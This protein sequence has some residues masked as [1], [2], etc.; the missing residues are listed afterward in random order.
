MHSSVGRS[1]RDEPS[2]LTTNSARY[3]SALRI[4]SELNQQG[5]Q[6]DQAILQR[7]AIGLARVTLQSHASASKIA[8]HIKN[9]KWSKSFWSVRSLWLKR[10]TCLTTI[11]QTLCLLDALYVLLAAP[12]RV[13]FFFD[14]RFGPTQWTT[15]LSV[16]LVLDVLGLMLR[17]Y[18]FQDSLLSASRRLGAWARATAQT[19]VHPIRLRQRLRTVVKKDLGSLTSI[20]RWSVASIGEQFVFNQQALANTQV[21]DAQVTPLHFG[22]IALG[23]IPWEVAA[24][25]VDYN[26]VHIV[27]L[28][29]VLLAAGTLPQRFSATIVARFHDRASIQLLSFSTIGVMV[30]LTILGLYLCHVVG[31]GYMLVAHIECGLRFELCDQQAR[32]PQSWVAKDQ[33]VDGSLSRQYVRTLYWAC[34]TMTTLGQGDLV[35]ATML[36][37]MYRVIVQFLAGLWAT[38]L[39]T[40]CSVF[41]SHKD[42]HINTSKS[43]RLDQIRQFLVSRT[44]PPAVMTNVAAYSTYIQRTRR[45]VE[46]VFVMAQLP[47]HYRV[48]CRNF[49][50]Y[51]YLKR[52]PGFRKRDSRF[53]RALLTIMERDFFVPN[54]VVVGVN[55]A[56]DMLIVVSGEIRVLDEALQPLGRLTP[57]NWHAEHALTDTTISQ[58]LLIADTF[59]ELWRLR[60]S[61][62]HTALGLRPITRSDEQSGARR[63]RSRTDS[64]TLTA[65]SRKSKTQNAAQAEGGA[66]SALKKLVQKLSTDDAKQMMKVARWRMPNSRFQQLWRRAHCILLLFILF[67]IPYHIAFQRGFS[68]F[69]SHEEAWV[70]ATSLSLAQTDFALSVLIEMFFMADMVLHANFFVRASSNNPAVQ[71]LITS[72]SQIF[73]HYL[74][75]E[76]YRLDLLANVPLPLL[77]DITPKLKMRLLSVTYLRYVRLLRLLR[78]RHLRQQLSI[79]MAEY[80]ITPSIRLLVFTIVF[81]G[82]AAHYAGCVFFLVADQSDFHG[83]LPVDFERVNMTA[84]QCLEHA[85]RHGNCTWYIY[86]RHAFDIPAPFLRSLH[87]SIVLLT[88]VGYGD[89]VAY[90][91]VESVVDCIWIFVSALICYFTGCAISSVLAHWHVLHSLQQERLEEI[92]IVLARLPNVPSTTA[93][94]IRNY[95]QTTWQFQGHTMLERELLAH[96]PRSLRYQI[97]ESLYVETLKYCELFAKCRSDEIF[98]QTVAH[99][100][101]T[102]IFLHNVT[103][104]RAGHTAQEVYVIQS[105][106]VEVFFPATQSSAMRR[107]SEAKFAQLYNL[108]QRARQLYAQTRFRATTTGRNMAATLA[109]H[110]HEAPIESLIPVSRLEVGDCFGLESVFLDVPQVHTTSACVVATAQVAVLRR[111]ELMRLRERFPK[112]LELLTST[113]TA[114]LQVHEHLYRN[115]QDNA[116]QRK[117]RRILGI[118]IA[119]HA[120]I[121]RHAKK[122]QTT[123]LDPSSRRVVCWHAAH[124]VIVVYNFYQIIFRIAFLPNP[125]LTTLWWLTAIDYA[126]DVFLYVDIFLKY[127][128][129]GYFEFGEKVLNRP[130]IQERY[131]RGWLMIHCCGMLPTFYIGDAQWMN[132]ARLPRLLRSAQLASLLDD[133]QTKLQ[134]RY[135]HSSTVLLNVFDLCKFFL[136]FVSTAHYIGSLYYLIGRLQTEHDG[137]SWISV[138][139][140]LKDHPHNVAVHYMRAMYWC[141]STFTVDCF[142]DIWAQN[143]LETMFCIFSCVL[144]WIFVGQVITKI[145]MLM[146]TL[147]RDAKEQHERVA[148]FEQLAATHQLPSALRHRA[149]KAL[150]YTSECWVQLQ[151]S[152]TFRDLPYALYVQLCYDMHAPSIAAVPEFSGLPKC[153][154]EAI[155][156]ALRVA[157][158]LRGDVIYDCHRVATTVL[159]VKHGLAELYSPRTNVVYGALAPGMAFATIAIVGSL[160]LFASVRAV[161]SCLVLLL[162]RRTWRSLWPRDVAA[163]VEN[164][165]RPRL[166]AEYAKHV[167]AS[168]NIEKN[169]HRKRETTQ[170]FL[171][172]QRRLSSG[173]PK[174][175]AKPEVPHVMRSGPRISHI[176]HRSPLVSDV[177]AQSRKWSAEIRR[178]S[179]AKVSPTVAAILAI[180]GT[181]KGPRK[182]TLTGMTAVGVEGSG[183]SE[184]RR[185]SMS[186]LTREADQRSMRS[187]PRGDDRLLTQQNQL[188]KPAPQPTRKR[189]TMVPASSLWRR[190]LQR[191]QTFTIHEDALRALNKTLSALHCKDRRAS[192]SITMANVGSLVLPKRRRSVTVL[193]SELMDLRASLLRRSLEKTSPTPPNRPKPS[194]APP[195]KISTQHTRSLRNLLSKAQLIERPVLSALS[196]KSEARGGDADASQARKVEIHDGLTTATGAPTSF[197]SAPDG[198][199]SV[200]STPFSTSECSIWMERSHKTI[201]FHETSSFRFWWDLIML[202]ISTYH[203]LVIPFRICFLFDYS[204]NDAFM[205]ALKVWFG[206][207]YVLVDGL[208]LVDYWLRKYRFSF[209]RHGETISD[210]AAIA[211]HYWKHG[212]GK[213]DLLAMLPL[214]LL[215]VL[216]SECGWRPASSAWPLWHQI[217]VARTNRL[218]RAVNFHAHAVRVQERLIVE[219]KLRRLRASAVPVLRLA[220]DFALGIHW[221]SCLFYSISFWWFDPKQRSWLTEPGMLTF[222]GC[223]GLEG[224]VQV[225]VSHRYIRSVHFSIGAITTVCYGD[226]LPL[227]T[228]ENMATLAVILFSV[229]FFS[230]L[231]GGFFKFFEMELGKRADYEEKVTQVGQYMVF[232]QFPARIWHQMQVYFAMAWHES[233]GMKEEE[234][235][236][237]LNQSIKEAIL[238]HMRAKLITSVRLLQT[239][240]E[241]LAKALVVLLDRHLY[242]RGDVIVQNGDRARTLFII[243]NGLVSVRT[244]RIQSVRMHRRSSNGSS[245]R[246]TSK[247]R[248]SGISNATRRITALSHAEMA[249]LE[250]VEATKVSH[251]HK[252]IKGP[253]DYFGEHCVLFGVTSNFTAVAMCVSRVYTLPQDKYQQLLEAFPEFWRKNIAAW[254]YQARADGQ[255]QNT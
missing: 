217:F 155:A 39:L 177:M 104:V 11:Y 31:C 252:A 187:T 119:T 159:I 144:G 181:E 172:R 101:R 102:E 133:A 33:L 138:D 244:T 82:A 59:C 227:N 231:S 214:E 34:K 27:C 69:E 137:V 99:I 35:P 58:Q 238:L 24:V 213:R 115:V 1:R 228:L 191:L 49:I 170:S 21:K 37:T 139:P 20:R 3:S 64:V 195:R 45:G 110:C 86:D 234:M 62:L 240:N 74:E 65:P 42:L 242:V 91:T 219:A 167:T 130:A 206:I 26:L 5:V 126:C 163:T 83:G 80:G 103:I 13:G 68:A 186:S 129:F 148:D 38:A 52:I 87:W 224:I 199:F 221:V 60:R 72:R 76:S 150:K 245:R 29:H 229:S 147:D 180:T 192:I 178:K 202:L 140:I 107:R 218:L 8:P 154:I 92:N 70:G 85:S 211:R 120:R 66:S 157:V 179:S 216:I 197:I 53:F 9:L 173:A 32:V 220:I 7:A 106:E 121:N 194:T 95:Y 237:G 40:S 127:A 12:L 141:L 108:Y 204:A 116:R 122:Q 136:V 253:F 243:E 205:S 182:S 166:T 78:L 117:T 201:V 226:I 208:C 249:G 156:K 57:G 185:N 196:E 50:C 189:S 113:A 96:V 135:L 233:K 4:D 161:H 67:E 90:S 55:D 209:L 79:T 97:V 89:I 158:F 184:R 46:E 94:M 168:L 81:C 105:G 142:G 14:P 41:F 2:S 109:A 112:H 75:N 98:L 169:L 61:R 248:Q 188:H 247:P 183:A 15:A 114:I 124:A 149:R 212:S 225:P 176:P 223:D 25:A 241:A 239:G 207:E 88:T 84:T 16:F 71:I 36:E 128:V 131:R 51:R 23:C 118:N 93:S 200:N 171:P 153:Q 22:V 190:H 143:A 132:V 134:E 246:S 63:H 146:I 44:M 43:T 165:L 193:P 77:W 111:H 175:P 210:S 47:P 198:S 18:A 125:T 162:D 232:H 56:E 151:L 10:A 250:A 255:H 251:E 174:V 203:L 254:V 17:W 164:Q 28:A 6:D 48:Q 215:P 123:T 230:M 54:Q 152:T 236:R 235:M 19:R 30:T 100:L 160:R 222:E 145:N 73:R